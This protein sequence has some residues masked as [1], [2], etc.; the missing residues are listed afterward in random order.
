MVSAAIATISARLVVPIVLPAIPVLII[1]L[2]LLAKV[3]LLVLLPVLLIVCTPGLVL[4]LLAPHIALLVSPA[5]AVALVGM[6]RL[7]VV[8]ATLTALASAEAATLLRD[9][10]AVMLVMAT[11]LVPRLLS[12]P[13]LL[14]LAAL[15]RE[16]P[17]FAPVAAQ[18]LFELAGAAAVVVAHGVCFSAGIPLVACIALF[19][20][21][22]LA[23]A[24]AKVNALVWHVSLCGAARLVA[25]VFIT[26]AALSLAPA[27]VLVLIAAVATTL[28]FA[29]A[30]SAAG[31]IFCSSAYIGGGATGSVSGLSAGSCL[32][33][34]FCRLLLFGT[35]LSVA[36]LVLHL[37]LVFAG[38]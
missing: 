21:L 12:A 7:A 20:K 27:A 35:V 30:R 14:V 31:N 22:L 18:A 25:I 19:A 34:G 32:A 17:V 10:A 1:V 11:H 15:L 38:A 24:I 26:F 33:E 4:A 2:L 29:S 5:R 28:I 37:V 8:V 3:P 6:G 9:T 13:A 36:A 16:I 23:S